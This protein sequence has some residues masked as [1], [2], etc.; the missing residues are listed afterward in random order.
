MSV[1]TMKFRGGVAHVHTLPPREG[2]ELID[3]HRMQVGQFGIMMEGPHK[4]HLMYKHGVAVFSLSD[5]G[6]ATTYT[7]YADCS[8]YEGCRPLR[9]SEAITFIQSPEAE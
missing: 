8:G 3:A 4:G 6:G 7:T 5:V 2:E 1:Q 9:P